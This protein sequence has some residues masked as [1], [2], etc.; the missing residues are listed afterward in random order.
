MQPPPATQDSYLKACLVQAEELLALGN[1]TAA[2]EHATIALHQ[3]G[4]DIDTKI[5]ALLIQGRVHYS[6]G[7]PDKSIAKFSLALQ[8]ADRQ[9]PIAHNAKFW[10]GLSHYTNGDRQAAK[11]DWEDLANPHDSM[12]IAPSLRAAALSRIAKLQSDEGCLEDAYCNAWHAYHLI[13]RDVRSIYFLPVTNF[14]GCLLL[15][16]HKYQECEDAFSDLIEQPIEHPGDL[17]AR[18][19][20]FVAESR[21]KLKN[22]QGAMA[23]CRNAIY[24]AISS[25]SEITVAAATDLLACGAYLHDEEAT[26]EAKAIL[27]DRQP[28]FFVENVANALVQ[29][30]IYRFSDD[31]YHGIIT[32]LSRV[33]EERQQLPTATAAL[34]LNYRAMAFHRAGY[35]DSAIGDCNEV[36]AGLAAYGSEAYTTALTNR[37][38]FADDQGD[39]EKAL[40]DYTSA[41][42]LAN[43]SSSTNCLTPLLNRAQIYRKLGF[44]NEALDD[45]NR[46]TAVAI[47]PDITDT[48]AR[49]YIERGRTLGMLG[50]SEAEVAD[51]THVIDTLQGVSKSI[52]VSALNARALGW[53]RLAKYDKCL[54]DCKLVVQ[55]KDLIDQ[56]SLFL[57]MYTLGW[58]K[59][60]LGFNREAL[61]NFADLS[62]IAESVDADAWSAAVLSKGFVHATL[63]EFTL[64]VADYT[65]LIDSCQAIPDHYLAQAYVNRGAEYAT[66]LG[67]VAHAIDDFD[68]AIEELPGASQATVAKALF[69]RGIAKWMLNEDGSFND[70]HRAAELIDLLGQSPTY[71]DI[72]L[73]RLSTEL[74]NELTPEARAGLL[75]TRARRLLYHGC[76]RDS[77]RDFN[78]VISMGAACSRE[79]LARAWEAR[80]YWCMITGDKKGCTAAQETISGLTGSL[81]A[82]YQ[83]AEW[84]TVHDQPLLSGSKW[85]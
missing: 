48:I 52:V 41:I 35:T 55:Q 11:T 47:V 60:Y 16:I 67:R 73:D 54:A 56:E 58:S 31:D 15:D 13:K 66:R 71:L 78:E 74:E 46:L 5:E 64:G 3:P 7:N 21:W 14:L 69:G 6:E 43:G 8:Q 39:L 81:S 34:A 25:D 70:C 30:C 36:L 75:I 50:K 68:K 49:A 61:L 85:L 33:L 40:L 29:C 27:T 80:M 45:L 59:Y 63:G 57:A 26:A 2:M 38:A 84:I 28:A 20:Y 23:S 76:W 19:H 83:A 17:L 18:A 65:L 72:E 1:C 51:Y 10:R 9:K 79:Q 77:V 22:F 62:T 53:S 44:M 37:G 82:G 24:A 12:P 42:T 32:E 4:A